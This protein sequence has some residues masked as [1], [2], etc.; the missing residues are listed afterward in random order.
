MNKRGEEAQLYLIIE[1]VIGILVA[2]LF[3]S[4]AT[5]YDSYSNIHKIFIEKDLKLLSESLLSAPGEI[6]FIYPIKSY[7]DVSISST[8]IQVQNNAQLIQF[9]TEDKLVF[10]KTDDLRVV[11]Q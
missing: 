11:R 1:I 8:E 5:N 3:I 9:A 4:M 10:T 6:E 2:G 7:Y